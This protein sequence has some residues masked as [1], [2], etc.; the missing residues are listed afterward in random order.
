MT[1]NKDVDQ[2]CALIAGTAWLFAR[3][4]FDQKFDYLFVDEAGQVSLANIVA[5]GMSARN[6]VLIGDQMQ[7]S[8]PIQGVHP[9]DSGS[10]VLEYLLEDKATVQPDK[11]IFLPTTRRMHARVCQFISDAVYDGRLKPEPDN[12][13]QKLLLAKNA[14][15]ALA[16]TGITVFEVKHSGCSQKSEEEAQAVRDIYAVL[17]GQRWVDRKGSVNRLEEIKF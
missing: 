7:L 1:D 13:N 12:Q 8:Q 6:V 10:S 5:M 15:P 4:E 2:S 17:I 9:G 3:D 16:E 14:H 11:G